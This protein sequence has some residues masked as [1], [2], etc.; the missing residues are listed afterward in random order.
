MALYELATDEIIKINE[1]SFS[2]VGLRERDD[3]QR[4]LKSQIEVI[5]PDTLVIA[6]EFGDW[7]DSRR[8]IDLLA[9]DK[10]A[11]LVVVELKRTE[12]GG[13]MEL[14]AIRYAAMVSTITFDKAV[15][16]YSQYLK[17]LGQEND[18]CKSILEFLDWDEPDDDQFAQDVRIVLASAEFG[19]EL[20][21]AVMWLNERDI[22]IKCVRIK[23]YRDN[24]R[25]LIDVQQI[26]PLPE[27]E[28]YQIQIRE[29]ETRERIARRG[30]SQLG[31][32]L[33]RFWSGLLELAN[34][35]TD[36]H[37]R[38]S[39][40]KDTYIGTTSAGLTFCYAF[41]RKGARVEIY[42]DKG[43]KEVNKAIYDKLFAS[44]EDIEKSHGG[45]LYWQRLD[46]KR[47]SRISSELNSA[48]V[49]DETSWPSLQESL[50][51][52]MIRFEKALR[53]FLDDLHG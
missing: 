10:D 25:V 46:D 32:I 35:K 15:E 2:E 7:E 31:E 37:S 3:L 13:H 41:G 27:A 30:Q 52:M 26:I 44:K 8:R 33:Y 20:T 11:N 9:I 1:T 23:P 39:P 16:V 47:A 40:S 49:R 45:V 34:K 6:E 36:L 17:R 22:D 48:S 29:K 43:S 4:L 18:A 24:G 21:T 28:A 38:I 19:K 12:D 42:I 53:P 14:Q 51:E 5:A 50:V